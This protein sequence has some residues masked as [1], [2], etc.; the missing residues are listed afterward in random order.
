MEPRFKKLKR[1]FYGWSVNGCTPLNQSPQDRLTNLIS[2]AST[3]VPIVEMRRGGGL[4]DGQRAVLG[5]SLSSWCPI[6]GARPSCLCGSRPGDAKWWAG[7]AEVASI[8]PGCRS[9]KTLARACSQGMGSDATAMGERCW[10]LEGFSMVLKN[11][12]TMDCDGRW[13]LI[14]QALFLFVWIYFSCLYRIFSVCFSL[15]RLCQYLYWCESAW[16]RL[17]PPWLL[18]LSYFHASLGHSWSIDQPGDLF[19]TTVTL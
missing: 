2:I 7:V 18:N 10:A 16:F 9:Q 3:D 1:S 15:Y 17:L 19:G 11:I 6:L 5:M 8:S 4:V 12:L 13:L 14:T